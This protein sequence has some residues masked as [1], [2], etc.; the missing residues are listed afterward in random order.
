MAITLCRAVEEGR[1]LTISEKSIPTTDNMW[2]LLYKLRSAYLLEGR[3]GLRKSGESGGVRKS[4]EV[5]GSREG[6]GS[7]GEEQE[8]GGAFKT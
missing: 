6:R 4:G 8:R 2:M 5:E 1:A 7:E 3:G